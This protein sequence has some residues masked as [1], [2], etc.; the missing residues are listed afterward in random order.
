[1]T[2]YNII[3]TA[4]GDN[5]VKFDGEDGI[6]VYNQLLHGMDVH[7]L[8][9]APEGS[10]EEKAEVIIPFHAVKQ[11]EIEATVTEDPTVE[12]AVCNETN[13][14]SGGKESGGKESGGEDSGD[15]TK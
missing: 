14:E 1:M 5:Q 6:K 15:P 2:T 11:A 10:S 4:E 13:T 7:A 9:G 3:L 12:D 8:G